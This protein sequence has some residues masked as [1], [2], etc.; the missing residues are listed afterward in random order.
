MAVVRSAAVAVRML[1]AAGVLMMPEG[2]ALPGRDGG[3]ALQRNRQGDRRDDENA[4]HGCRHCR[5]LYDS[6]FE[7]RFRRIGGSDYLTISSG[8]EASC[9]TLVAV[10][11]TSALPSALMPRLPMQIRSQREAAARLTM[12]SAIGPTSA[13]AW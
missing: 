1:V 7:R 3:D 10:E 13:L 12:V 11:P 2:H 8:C 9:R 6:G 4:D 5:R